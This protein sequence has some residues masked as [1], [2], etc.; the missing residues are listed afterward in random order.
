M[1]D[2]NVQFPSFK[3][4]GSV[5]TLVSVLELDFNKSHAKIIRILL[6]MEAF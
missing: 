1:S 2:C 6:E 5:S 3:A 4:P